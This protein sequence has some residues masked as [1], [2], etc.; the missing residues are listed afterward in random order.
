M[1]IKKFYLCIFRHE[2]SDSQSIDQ[3]NRKE[4]ELVHEE[5]SPRSFSNKGRGVLLRRLYFRIHLI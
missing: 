4:R 2:D 5:D 3:W 1:N